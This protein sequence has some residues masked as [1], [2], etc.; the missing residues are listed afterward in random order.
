MPPGRRLVLEEG[1]AVPMRDG[2][3]LP[4]DLFLPETPGA[5]PAL[6]Q[7]TPYNR[8]TA[9]ATTI[10]L[11]ARRAV[12]A[13]YAVVIQD[14]RGRYAAEGDF[15]PFLYEIEDGYDTVEWVAAQPWCNGRVGMFGNSYV[16][17]TQW[18][19]VLA[20]PPHLAAI[21]PTVTAADYHE[22]WTYQGGA[23]SLGFNATWG[24]ALA[25][26]Q[27]GR[28]AG[29]NNADPAVQ[30]QHDALD[31][32][33]GMVWELPLDDLTATEA[34]PAYRDWLAHP[35][36]DDYW[37]R[38]RIA[39]HYPRLDLPAFHT[40]GW[41][42]IFLGGTLRNYTGMRAAAAT[43]GAR[44]AQR[45]VVGPW[46]HYLPF[47]NKVGDHHLVQKKSLAHGTVCSA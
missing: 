6:L 31:G 37:R 21:A 38:W 12:R 41:H 29:W 46:S 5:W 36:L 22:G 23:F 30:R 42:D 27:L 24:A 18:L 7:R 8:Q 45:L 16:G 33:G 20:R 39:D 25:L 44:A 34:L 35:D 10:M 40:G 4:A 15:T 32:L 14:T 13:G 1:V 9:N 28:A 43:P 19:A 17:A 11:D 2:A 26:A 47:D 3:I